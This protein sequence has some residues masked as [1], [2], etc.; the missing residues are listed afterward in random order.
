MSDAPPRVPELAALPGMT[1]KRREAL[2]RL[3]VH[4]CES[5]L[6]LAPRRYEDRRHPT[7]IAALDA[8]APALVIGRVAS[9]RARRLRG[10]LTMLSARVCDA[11]GEID[12]R[13]FQRGYLP[14]PLPSDQRI[15]LYGTPRTEKDSL[16]FV[17]A[18][19]ER[20]PAED[21]AEEHPGAN[22]LVPV[23][24]ATKGVTAP[25]IRRA[26]WE[27]LRADML[28][29]DPVPARHLEGL[30][31]NP[32]P[33][34]LAQLHFPDTLESA[35]AARQRLAYDE[36][37]LH[38]LQRA[39]VRAT[40]RRR[41]A[42]PCPFRP[43]VHARI[44]ERLPFTLTPGQ[45]S[46]V[47][48]LCED[49]AQPNPMNRLLQGDVGS[50][51]TAVAFYAA[52]GVIAAG[53]QVAFLAPTEVLARQHAETLGSWLAGSRVR[54]ALLLGARRGAERRKD[55]VR[56]AAGEVDLVIGTHALLGT[57]PAFERLGLVVVDEQHRFGVRQRRALLARGPE[58]DGRRL[59]PHA[60]VMTATPIPRTLAQ[61]LHGELD[62]T[63]V[64]GR[65]PGRQPV[66]TLVV[67][68]REGRAL[69]GRIQEELAAG[70]QAFVIYPLVEESENMTLR[71]AVDGQTRWQRALPDHR[72]GLLHGRMKSAEKDEVMAR[73]RAAEIDLLVSTVV[74]EV[75]VDVPRASVLVVEHAERFGLSQLHQL[76]G[77]IGRGDRGGLCV[78]VDRTAKGRARRLQV[79]ARS[80]DGFEIAEEDL[81]IR[82]AGDLLGTRQHG[83]PGF[84]AA[85]LPRDMPLLEAAGGAARTILAADPELAAEAHQGLL[86]RLVR[87]STEPEDAATEPTR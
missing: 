14:R 68:P 4:D 7:P 36:L 15:A 75:G 60:L 11:S 43:A 41:A 6:R 24:P 28:P 59:T 79:L 3:G 76:R 49:L 56:I 78:F 81:R 22:R 39:R 5:L 29:V 84:Q 58:Q 86:A 61:T 26:I 16:V 70:H 73:F 37:L 71:D 53:Y 35:E 77:R 19:L 23:H 69:F 9:S 65:P 83:H 8:E 67:R 57:R 51:K 64:E 82:G 31:L 74:I 2:L 12:A 50:G 46:A 21:A 18:A 38:E 54:Q 85:S 48:T 45:E 34:A 80:A 10:G 44:R 32:L 72:V 1:A 27:A 17:G 40:R 25:V 55:E 47:K 52:M 66:E 33:A 20:L 87:E 63:I 30:G 13:W 42:P 62:V